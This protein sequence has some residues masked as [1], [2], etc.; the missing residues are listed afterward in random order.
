MYIQNQIIFAAAGSSQ[1]LIKWQLVMNV[2]Y[3]TS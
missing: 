1:V 2:A 3:P